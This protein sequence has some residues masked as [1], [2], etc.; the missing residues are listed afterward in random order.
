MIIFYSILQL[1]HVNNQWDLEFKDLEETFRKYRIDSQQAQGENHSLISTLK[2]EKEHLKEKNL[3][4]QI[5]IR[6]RDQEIAGLKAKVKS[7][8]EE[9]RKIGGGIHQPI[10]SQRRLKELEEES[11]MLRQQVSLCMQ[12]LSEA[13][14][15]IIDNTGSMYS[16]FGIKLLLFEYAFCSYV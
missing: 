16:N 10:V 8:E 5:D 11:Q 1:M 7:L 6:R 4:L 2:D 12:Y 3:E 14:G 15:M 9:I 13:L